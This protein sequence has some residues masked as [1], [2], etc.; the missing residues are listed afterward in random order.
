MD[1]GL[2][3]VSAAVRTDFQKLFKCLDVSPSPSS[4]KQQTNNHNNSNNNNG[5]NNPNPAANP[6][7]PAH[8]LHIRQ[9]GLNPAFPQGNNPVQLIHHPN[10]HYPRH[11]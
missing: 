7:G 1:E 5:A 11:Q 9:N 2:S 8:N 3:N 4:I 6:A 10:V